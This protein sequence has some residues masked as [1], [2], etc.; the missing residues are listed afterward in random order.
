MDTHTHAHAHCDKM[1]HFFLTVSL[2]QKYFKATVVEEREMWYA[3]PD[4]PRSRHPDKISHA[5]I[6]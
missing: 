2:S 6:I 3:S 4:S 1:K 5:G